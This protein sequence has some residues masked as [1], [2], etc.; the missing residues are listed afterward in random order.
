MNKKYLILIP[1]FLIWLM[2]CVSIAYQGLFY[3]EYLIKFLRKPPQEYDYPTF[4]VIILCLI[5]ALWMSSYA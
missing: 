2:A 5:Y 1:L 4:Q 3:S